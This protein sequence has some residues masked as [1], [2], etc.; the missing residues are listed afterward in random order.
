M[1]HCYNLQSLK[2]F[3]YAFKCIV[4]IDKLSKIDCT[5]SELCGY[6]NTKPRLN[7]KSHTTIFRVLLTVIIYFSRYASL[8]IHVTNILSHFSLRICTESH[9]LVVSFHFFNNINIYFVLFL[10]N[11]IMEFNQ[12]YL[13]TTSDDIKKTTDIIS[14][15]PSELILALIILCVVLLVLLVLTS[16]GFII[17]HHHINLEINEL[18]SRDEEDETDG[19][20][21]PDW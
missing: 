19:S 5:T 17:Y 2:I 15:E 11:I 1:W 9:L 7:N 14:E 10:Y 8:C 18:H 12:S 16:A 4:L 6:K 13:L 21:L 20:F 3:L